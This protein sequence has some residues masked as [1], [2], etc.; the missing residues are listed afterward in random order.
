MRHR[1][2]ILFMF[3]IILLSH[4]FLFSKNR[5]KVTD[6]RYPFFLLTKNSPGE[7]IESTGLIYKKNGK[8]AGKY[9]LISRSE[10]SFLC[11]VSRDLSGIDESCFVDSNFSEILKISSG[12]EKKRDSLNAGNTSE[13]GTL[14][15]NGIKF[16]RISGRVFLSAKPELLNIIPELTFAGIRKYLEKADKH[17]GKGFKCNFWSLEDFN[18]YKKKGQKGDVY[19]G[20]VDG[21][22]H[23][24]YWRS[25]RYSFQ[26]ISEDTL[27]AVCNEI[28]VLFVLKGGR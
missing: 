18:R 19:L 26:M 10:N 25:G 15:I 11:R 12:K 21:R 27:P 1:F 9:N 23:M 7:S 2:V 17:A 8:V 24:I 28:Y 6:V 20:L 5:L 22:L 14:K 3:L 4:I 16:E 13:K